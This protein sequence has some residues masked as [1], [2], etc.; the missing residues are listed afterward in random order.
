MEAHGLID[1]AKESKKRFYYKVCELGSNI[2]KLEEQIN[3]NYK[4]K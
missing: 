2:E 4:R 3:I 1:Q